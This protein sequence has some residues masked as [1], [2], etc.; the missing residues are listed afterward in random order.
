MK[1]A[2]PINKDPVSEIKCWEDYENPESSDELDLETTS[3]LDDEGSK[4]K[5]NILLYF[6]FL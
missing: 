2:N 4:K 6:N 3:D 1:I 5:Y